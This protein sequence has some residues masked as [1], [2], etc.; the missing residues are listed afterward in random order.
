MESIPRTLSDNAGLDQVDILVA[1]RAAH[2]T[3]GL[4]SGINVYNGAITE[5]MKEGDLQPVKEKEHAIGSAGEGGS[6]ILR[7]DE[8][9]A[10]A[11]PPPMPRG[12][13]PPADYT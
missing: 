10:A 3:K 2:E 6:M 4:W 13:G 7:T 8:G 12:Q 9:I 5:M 1:L 11:K